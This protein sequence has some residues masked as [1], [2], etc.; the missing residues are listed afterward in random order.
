MVLNALAFHRATAPRQPDPACTE[1][2]PL[3]RHPS[4]TDKITSSP[5]S[6]AF[7]PA[8]QTLLIF[9]SLISGSWAASQRRQGDT[10][11]LRQ[12]GRRWEAALLALCDDRL[13]FKEVGN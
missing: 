4:V 10:E 6:T 3:H 11:Q 9:N 8:T 7:S 13:F 5:C 12:L 1:G 2:L